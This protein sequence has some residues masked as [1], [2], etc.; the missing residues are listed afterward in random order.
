MRQLH[1]CLVVGLGVKNRRAMAMMAQCVNPDT[2]SQA[3]IID[4]SLLSAAAAAAADYRHTYI[5]TDLT[6]SSLPQP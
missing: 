3:C 4:I 2:A 1:E 5:A 6:N